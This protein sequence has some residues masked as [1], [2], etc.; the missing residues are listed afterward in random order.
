MSQRRL[1]P[2]PKGNWL[3]GNSLAY[4]RSP[5]RFLLESAREF[6]D[7]VRL[8]VPGMTVYMLTH[9]ELIEY[10]LRENARNFIKD[11]L[12]R[13]TTHLLG[14]GLLT[15]EGEFWRRQRRLA[16]PAFQTSQIQKYAPI[17][18]AATERMM[19]SWEDGQTRNVHEEMMGLALDIVARTLFGSELSREAHDVNDAMMT[20]MEYLLNPFAWFRLV[21]WIPRP[22]FLKF[23]RAIRR[24]DEILYGFIRHGRANG[25]LGD[26]LLSRLIAARDEDGSQMTDQQ[27]RDELMTLFLAGHETTAL[28]LSYCFY[29]LAQHPEVEARLRAE[30]DDVLQ[31]RAATV[32]DVPNLRYTEWVVRESM[33][34]YPPAWA[35]GR[36]PLTDCEIGGFHVPKGMQI[37]MVQ[38]VVHRDARWFDDP[39]RFRPERWDND[40]AR[41]LPRCAYFPFGDGPRICI[42]NN[43]AMMETVLVVATIMQKYS[44]TL[45]PDQPFKLL[46]S[47]TLR[48][49]FG[50]K[51]VLQKRRAEKPDSSLAEVT[52]LPLPDTLHIS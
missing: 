47:I 6:G 26:D 12:T 32:A 41:R 43:F 20:G 28:A 17:M 36:Q 10:V 14:P 22:G 31:G 13:Q 34:I 45:V 1:P 16:Q 48:P 21:K 37:W 8:K 51:M 5:L 4:I 25:A 30:V 35:I 2:G 52:P 3:I 38:W 39:E 40:L 29:L 44:M 33:R 18:V 50:I 11:K 42:G 15:S 19:E 7:I 24:L 49:K 27:L 46:P 9:P 23:G